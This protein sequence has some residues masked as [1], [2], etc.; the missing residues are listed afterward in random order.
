MVV[1]GGTALVLLALANE[2]LFETTRKYKKAANRFFACLL[3]S[4]L[5]TLAIPSQKEAA[6]IYL[7]PKLANSDF[8]GEVQQIPADLA[9]LL[10]LYLQDWLNDV[11]AGPNGEGSE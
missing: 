8:M 10:R 7:L 9:K 2:S 1:G 11:V 4:C 3:I 6:A 5:G